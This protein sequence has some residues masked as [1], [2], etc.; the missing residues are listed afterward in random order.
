MALLEM[1]LFSD[2]LGMASSVNIILPEILKKS[3]KSEQDERRDFKTEYPVLYL[4]HGLSDDHTSWIRRSSIE[5]YAENAGLAV[6][7]PAVHRSFYTDMAQG[8]DYF[9]YVSQELPRKLEKIFPL[10]TKREETFIAG[11]SM[12]GYGAFKLALN[13]PE[14]FAAAASLSGALNIGEHVTS[15]T[16]AGELYEEFKWI[17][18]DLE[19]VK[20]SKHDLFY[21]LKRLKGRQAEIPELYQCCGTEDFLY[22]DN[23]KFKKFCSKNNIKL[24]YEEEKADHEWWYWDKKIKSVIDWLPVKSK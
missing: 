14:K 12:G 19:K 5:R 4:L 21:L 15:K 17:F 13:F 24:K 1:N 10:T 20:N 9:T 8:Q 22:Q 2:S 18:G 23:L 11:L 16:E 3:I 7:M 6:I